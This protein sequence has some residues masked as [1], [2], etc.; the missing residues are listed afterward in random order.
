MYS[1]FTY[2][3][4]QIPSVMAAVIGRELDYLSARLD[5]HRRH[6]IRN[7]SFPGLLAGSLASTDGRVYSGISS[8]ELLLLDE[9]EAD[10]YN[11]VL[12]KVQTDQGDIS[13]YVYL[14]SDSYRHL[15]LDEDWDLEEFEQ[16]HLTAYLIRIQS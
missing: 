2:G 4:L 7:H 12:V 9:F 16:K 8:D 5:K 3:T 6:K 11:R 13:A 14:I 1:V 15:L 10:F